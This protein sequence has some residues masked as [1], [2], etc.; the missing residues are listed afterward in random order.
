MLNVAIQNSCKHLDGQAQAN[1]YNT[2]EN[3]KTFI[4]GQTDQ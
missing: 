1:S 3:V 2:C 4:S